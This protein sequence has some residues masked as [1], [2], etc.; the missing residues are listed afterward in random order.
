[1]DGTQTTT[2][3]IKVPPYT[4][5][6]TAG[7][8]NGFPGGTFGWGGTPTWTIPPASLLYPPNISESD[9]VLDLQRF[10]KWEAEATQEEKERNRMR[11][12]YHVIVVHPK[13]ERIVHE[14]RLVADSE[15]TA[16]MKADLPAGIRKCVDDFDIIVATLGSV[17]PKQEVQKVKVVKEDE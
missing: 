3:Y 12:L 6:N 11:H 13:T 8:T 15:S 10:Y 5:N 4:S 16:R 9:I 2:S 17:R 14:E 7:F 1:M